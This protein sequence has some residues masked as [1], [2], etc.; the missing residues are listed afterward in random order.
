MGMKTKTEQLCHHILHL[1]VNGPRVL[2]NLVM[3]LAASSSLPLDNPVR[4]SL[5][6][7]CHYHYS[8][9]YKAIKWLAKDAIEL[10]KVQ[11]MCRD[12][13]Y[14]HLVKGWLENG[15][16][17]VLHG[18]TTPVVKVH[19][20]TLEGR[21]YIHL[22][23]G[24]VSRRQNLSI[25]YHYS[26]LNL[27]LGQEGYS[28]PLDSERVGSGSTAGEV[29]LSQLGRFMAQRP[30]KAGGEAAAVLCLDNGYSGAPFLAGL[31]QEQE[32]AIGLIR[33]RY[34]RKV[35]VSQKAINPQGQA[36][37]GK[38]YC[39]ISQARSR[40][41]KRPNS[42]ERYTVIER[43]IFELPADGY[44][45]LGEQTVRG[46]KL[47]VQVWR[48]GNLLLR[49][50]KTTKH[51]SMKDKPLDVACI[52]VLDAHSREPVFSYD[53]FILIVGKKRAEVGIAQIRQY[54]ASR[55]DIEPYFRFA[56]RSLMLG[57]YQA[58]DIQCLDN[59]VA[60]A[61]MA[62]WLL[63]AA[64]DEVAACPCHAWEKY[65]PKG[66][67]GAPPPE[68]YRLSQVYRSIEKLLLGFDK[69]P[70]LPLKSKPGIGRQ[71]GQRPPPKKKHKVLRKHPKRTKK[72]A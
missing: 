45:E 49:A 32:E 10:R 1:P 48:W 25:G 19:S 71:A 3:A 46:R 50:H 39:L 68:R 65:L 8:A 60:I 52:R 13:Y 12:Y 21:G 35:F 14:R 42:E 11:K 61:G 63:F 9:L 29:M 5:S 62:S 54:Y 18:D 56:K 26:F 2:A 36:Y 27:G 37:Y 69:E 55:Y 34:G 28:L 15:Q 33:T 17:I 72:R 41:M 44:I 20:P 59:W 58:Q 57:S 30:A 43:S 64:S 23:N 31:C 70:F 47:A 67:K 51:G 22:P 6:R 7:L 40:K 38:E 53:Q 16:P 24:A 66:P 4:L